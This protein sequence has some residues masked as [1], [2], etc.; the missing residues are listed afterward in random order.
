MRMKI[1]MKIKMII[2]FIRNELVQKLLRQKACQVGENE[3]ARFLLLGL[4]R[5]NLQKKAHTTLSLLPTS[6]NGLTCRVVPC[7]MRVWTSVPF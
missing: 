7:T 2:I 4:M 1:E 5:K 3:L 6:A